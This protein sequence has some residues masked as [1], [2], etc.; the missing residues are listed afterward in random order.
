MVTGGSSDPDRHSYSS[1]LNPSLDDPSV[2]ARIYK[3]KIALR[4]LDSKPFGYGVG[5]ATTSQ[6]VTE[7]FTSSVAAYS[8]DSGYL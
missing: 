4:D 7:R 5:A 1:I 8:I 3:W 6:L 2:S